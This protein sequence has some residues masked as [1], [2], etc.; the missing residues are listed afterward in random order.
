M[1]I[2]IMAQ[3]VK[4][5]R[6]DCQK[7]PC[8]RVNY[9]SKEFRQKLYEHLLI[10]AGNITKTCLLMNLNRVGLY[11]AFEADEEFRKEFD[12]VRNASMDTAES[13][14]I[15]RAVDG[16]NK[17]IFYMGEIVGYER[18]YSDQ[19]LAR[20]MS[21]YRKNWRTTNAEISGPGGE[22]IPVKLYDF[23][24]SKFPKPDGA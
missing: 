3:P 23:D 16:V 8:R 24:A 1:G 9:K 22:P 14:A 10:T 6:G 12:K 5:R 4:G 2:S 21:A 20:L 11:Q 17:P 19:L 7:R 13:E 18:V 15:R